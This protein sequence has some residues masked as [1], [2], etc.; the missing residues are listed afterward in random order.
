MCLLGPVAGRHILLRGRDLRK[1]DEEWVWS[2]FRRLGHPGGRNGEIFA[3]ASVQTLALD[4]LL[5]PYDCLQ[6]LAVKLE[7]MSGVLFWLSHRPSA[8]EPDA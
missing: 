7:Q 4:G 1:P 2:E 8:L 6:A 5:L 3:V